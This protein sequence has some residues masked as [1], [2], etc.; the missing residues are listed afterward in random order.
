M[1]DFR[2]AFRTLIRNPVSTV[3]IVA[4][5][6]IGIG[7]CTTIFS[8]FDAVLLRP[9]PVSD[10]EQLIRI[11]QHLPKLPPRSSF[12]YAYY[13]ALRDHASSL[14]VVFGETGDDTHFRVTE[15]AAPQRIIVRG[16]TPEYFQALGVRP[17]WGRPLMA[18]DAAQKSGVPPAVLSYGF[19][20]GHFAGDP[21]NMAGKTLKINGHQFAIVG[22]MPRGFNGLSVD[23]S[24]DIQI[25][26]AAYLMLSNSKI[27]SAYFEVSG[28]A[29]P[30]RRWC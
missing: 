30:G 7:T 5:L 26:L 13:E 1:N 9:L 17:Y 25:P 12:P 19:W 2:F 11:V 3:L 14:S 22:I 10:P 29:R 27:E 6:G 8:L 18:D 24:P 16:V 4:L 21:R 28:R 20:R 23:V 15:P